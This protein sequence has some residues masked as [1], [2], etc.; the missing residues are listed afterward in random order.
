MNTTTNTFAGLRPEVRAALAAMGIEEPTP[1][2]AQAMPAMLDGRDVIGQARTGSGKTLA[3]VLP[4]V[5]R[6]DPHARA[7]QALVVVPTR[8]LA[9]QVGDVVARLAPARGL[10]H[11]LLYGGRSLVPEQRALRAGAQIVVGTPGRLLDHLRQG[12]LS[13]RDLRIL[14]L[15]E[16]DEMLDRGFA[17]DVERILAMTP[18]GR[19]T[20]LFSATVPDWVMNTA[21]KHLRQPAHARVDRDVDTPPEIEHVVYEIDPGAKLAALRS[22]LD[23][24]GESPMIVF[25]RTKHGVKKLA[26]QLAALGYP[27]E[28]LQG[29][30]S[31]NARERVMASFRSGELPILLATNVAA[32]GIDVGGVER[33]INFELPESAELFTHRS[34]RTGR[35][36]RQGEVITFVTPEDEPKWRQMERGLGRRL[37]RRAWAGAQTR[38]VASVAA[39]PA[40]PAAPAATGGRVAHHEQP[41][42]PAAVRPPVAA[43]ARTAP[44]PARSNE[45]LRARP[46]A[47]GPT[48]REV[49]RVAV[50]DARGDRQTQLDRFFERHSPV[51]A[52]PEAPAA[53]RPWRNRRRRGGRRPNGAAA[54]R[55]IGAPSSPGSGR[56]SGSASA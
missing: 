53:P 34:G 52:R 45:G 16:G 3:F 37:P 46:P 56:G 43:D 42:R 26:R 9:V 8:E 28:A 11:L 22:L 51:S 19:Q 49:R 39:P 33:V 55:P 7:V 20:A 44:P 15:D 30:M 41:R 2:Q 25:G 54:G 48:R 13:L 12:N 18:T 29:N 36:G 40:R 47:P 1:V 10:R 6:C 38:V 5:E 24:R 4:I 23:A 50:G 14:V 17:P 27:A 32:R 21:A 35:M 31:Q